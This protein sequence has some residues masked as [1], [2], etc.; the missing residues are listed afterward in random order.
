[1]RKKKGLAARQSEKSQRLSIFGISVR[2]SFG[3]SVSR[4][5]KEQLRSALERYEAQQQDACRLWCNEHP[6]AN[7]SS[8]ERLQV[9][10]EA[11]MGGSYCGKQAYPGFAN[12]GNVCY[13]TSV[14]Q[15]LIH[16]PDSRKALLDLPAH[17]DLES[18][19]SADGEVRKELR[20]VAEEIEQLP[21]QV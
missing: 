14:V 18:G 16:C 10:K 17:D 8:W 6:G 13:L 3:S 2:V 11:C 12:I 4:A 19:S 1:M 7:N 21:R 9:Q 20:R 15:C 5:R